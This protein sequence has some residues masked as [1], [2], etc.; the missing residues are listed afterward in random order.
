MSA[1]STRFALIPAAYIYLLSARGVLLQLRQGTGYMDGRWAAGAA[2]H[3][4]PGETAEAAAIRELREELG[5]EVEPGA[6]LPVA[7]MQRTDGTADPIEQRVDWF[8]TCRSWRGDPAIL[9]PEKCAGL[10]WFGL[11]RLPERMPPH[12]RIALD[13]VRRGA[14]ATLLSFGFDDAQ[15]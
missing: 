14:S 4:E 9:E 11:D 6:L 10:E 1:A 13:A 8:F 2:G 3:V 15:P 12:E 7:V 5:V